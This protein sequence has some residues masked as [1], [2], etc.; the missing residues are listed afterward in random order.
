LV[1][2]VLLCYSFFTDIVWL[3]Q[4]A[5]HPPKEPIVDEHP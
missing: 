3:R 1:G 4:Q 2:L 5:G